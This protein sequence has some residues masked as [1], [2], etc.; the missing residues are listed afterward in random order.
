MN[1]AHHF[2]GSDFIEDHGIKPLKILFRYS[3]QDYLEQSRMR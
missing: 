3:T 1:T 2:G